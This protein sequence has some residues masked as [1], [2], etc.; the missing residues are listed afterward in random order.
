[1]A[2]RPHEDA[3]R[4][5]WTLEAEIPLS[6]TAPG[7][8]WHRARTVPDGQPVTLLLVEGPT[9]L[10]A[11]DA[12]RRAYLVQSPRLMEVLDVTVL[13]DPRGRADDP[14]GE[15]PL[16]V[17]S[18]PVPSAPPLAALLKQGRLRPETAR[19]IIGEAAEALETARR[20]GVRHRVLDSNRI[21]VDTGAGTVQVLGVGVE[22]A[23]HGYHSRSGQA[24]FEDTTALVT[25]LYR[26]VTGSAPHRGEDGTV[27]RPS[28]LVARSI[29]P[30]LDL[31]CDLVLNESQNPGAQ[32]PASSR[33]VIDAL[34]PWQSIPVTLEAYDP[35]DRPEEEPDPA[36]R[37]DA[38]TPAAAPLPDE[39]PLPT[40]NTLPTEDPLATDPSETVSEEPATETLPAMGSAAPDPDPAVPDSPEPGHLSPF[41]GA[42]A[43]DAQQLIR[44]LHLD[45]P[46][47]RAPFPAVLPIA[48][49]A[50][51]PPV[52]QLP[53]APPGSS[54]GR[55]LHAPGS[56]MTQR[57]AVLGRG[58]VESAGAAAGAIVAA[59]ST[60]A[61]TTRRVVTERVGAWRERRSSEG[62]RRVDAPVDTPMDTPDGAATD[63]TDGP[64]ATPDRDMAA[65]PF[66]VPTGPIVV[67]GRSASESADA[68]RGALFREVLDIA[69][70]RD[71]GAHLQS[72]EGSDRS[73]HAQW[74]LLGAAVL[75]VLAMVLA[76]TSITSGSRESLT[77][78]LATQAPPSSPAA[79]ASP[80]PSAAASS[81][82]AASPSAAPA[83]PPR[84]TGAEIVGDRPD[85]PEWTDRLT[86]G[87]LSGRWSTKL[88]GSAEFGSVKDGVGIRLD[89]EG[90]AQ[91]TAVVVTSAANSGGTL[92][93]RSV[94]PDGAPGEVLASAPFA[95]DG[96]VRLA[97]P[98]PVTAERVMV[99][100]PQLPADADRDGRF[101]AHI[102]EIRAE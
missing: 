24:G 3:L 88:Y 77:N 81:S 6:G 82:P 84:V 12:A 39:G 95:G 97:P 47:S 100:I 44:E 14:D 99:W 15:D 29:P 40:E 86:D 96:E 17:V 9:A 42:A 23:A 62:S 49:P 74:I 43:Q 59:G 65:A 68:S 32:V 50:D 89:L 35:E 102:T 11:A 58:A 41:P 80:A 60:A 76:I 19:S 91:V 2:P 83:A 71:D 79:S 70:D 75:V 93:L 63:V 85:H 48:R 53:D 101:R 52:P 30:E 21:F 87:D 37:P 78:P 98:A 8:S 33:D 18:Y 4:A 28:Q 1:M 20:R 66:A 69:A 72:Y 13:G 51:A 57:A 45:E 22:A 61:G 27:P 55:A 67:K 5:R 26:A 90:P 54:V 64:R 25:L 94:A 16:T 38:S 31:L 46:R 10:E 36:P 7:A 92:E 34:E 73:R 56:P